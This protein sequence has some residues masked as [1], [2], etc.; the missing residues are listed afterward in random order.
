M[1]HGSVR[2]LAWSGYVLVWVVWADLPYTCLLLHDAGMFFTCPP[3]LTYHGS[4]FLGVT[5]SQTTISMPYSRELH[6]TCRNGSR[7]L[8]ISKHFTVMAEQNNDVHVWTSLR[9]CAC[10]LLTKRT[11]RN[12]LA[13]KQNFRNPTKRRQLCTWKWHLGL[14]YMVFAMPGLEQTWGWFGE[15]WVILKR[16]RAWETHGYLVGLVWSSVSTDVQ[17]Q[18]ELMGQ[19]LYNF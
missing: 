4:V 14:L 15:V 16:S 3:T 12:Y 11:E 5:Q 9:Y 8:A 17:R 13:D 1:A 2:S 10:G 19:R 6:S 18:S 7:F